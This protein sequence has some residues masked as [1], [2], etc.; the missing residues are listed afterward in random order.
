MTAE[1]KRIPDEIRKKRRQGRVGASIPRDGRSGIPER[2]A[3][4]RMRYAP[5]TI[6]RPHILN[7]VKTQPESIE[8]NVIYVK[9]EHP[10]QGKAP[11][12]WFLMTGE[13]ATGAKKRMSMQ[14]IICGG[15]RQSGF[16]MRLR[17]GVP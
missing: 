10:P 3:A 14:G 2:E 13:G 15:G 17:A 5:F 1:N 16:I 7:P 6:R 4:A 9:E 8:V 12:E 11:A